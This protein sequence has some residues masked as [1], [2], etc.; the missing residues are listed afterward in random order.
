MLLKRAKFNKCGPSKLLLS[1]FGMFNFHVFVSFK[2][3]IYSEKETR[4][5]FPKARNHS[6][7]IN[8]TIIPEIEQIN[9]KIIMLWI[10]TLKIPTSEIRHSINTNTV[11]EF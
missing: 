6:S 9:E 1:V 3:H 4:S 7:R 8:F 5:C 10:I 2:F 11:K